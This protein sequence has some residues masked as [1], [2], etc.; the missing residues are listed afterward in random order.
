[1]LGALIGAGASLASGL[2]GN[3]S[4][5]KAQKANIA[6]E[7]ARNEQNIALQKE[8]AQSGIQWKVSDAEKAGVH[9]LF[10]LGAQTTSF[11]PTSIGGGASQSG[12]DF[13][14]LADAGQNIGRAIDST[15]ST[16]ATAMALQLAKI[17]LEGAG[18]DNDLKRTQLLSALRT[19]GI[20]AHPPL[21]G[22]A[23]VYPLP[24]QSSSGIISSV[25]PG[26]DPRA[27][28]YT[29]PDLALEGKAWKRAPGTSDAQTWEDVYGDESLLPFIINN[30]KGLRD[31]WY[32]TAPAYKKRIVDPLRR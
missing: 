10:A 6:A 21:P 16:P 13:S 23:D 1:M 28:Q 8:F 9:P 29:H 14:A 19:N 15:R 30:Y 32:N 3:K 7:N 25:P 22:A 11:S 17:Q 24:G 2:L 5:E 18:L 26:H 31:I 27:P 12:S 4:Q 20:G